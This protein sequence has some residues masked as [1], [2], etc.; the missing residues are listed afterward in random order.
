MQK[1]SYICYDGE[2]LRS[3]EHLIEL[4]NRGFRYGD[5]LFET[6][7]GFGTAVQFLDNHLRRLT[8]GMKVLKMEIPGYFD[9]EY[10]RNR[11]EGLLNKNRIYKGVIL[12]LTVFRKGK[13]TYAAESNEVSYLIES[14]PIETEKYALNSTGYVI[15]VYPELKK[16][17]NILSNLKTTNSLLFVLAGVYS[18]ENSLDDCIIINEKDRIAEAPGSNIFVVKGNKIYTPGL[19]EGCLAGTMRLTVIHILTDAGFAVNA[20]CSLTLGDLEEA[21]EIFLTNAIVGV[22]WVLAFRQRRYFNKTAKLIVGK[23]NDL[24]FNS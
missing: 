2:Y 3:D 9:E 8:S 6:M 24:A 5:A 12:R 1:K 16:P 18:K 11:I 10:F 23:I 15:D 4:T 19:K 21:D 13:G 20:D 17:I 7:H 22:R 14:E